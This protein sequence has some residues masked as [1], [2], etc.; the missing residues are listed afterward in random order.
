MEDIKIHKSSANNN[1]QIDPADCL[2]CL[3]KL[4]SEIKYLKCAHGFHTKC[5]N[6][7]LF[8][9]NT[10]PICRCEIYKPL[11]QYYQDYQDLLEFVESLN[12]FIDIDMVL[13]KDNIL[14][15][16]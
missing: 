14:I 15:E 6:Q 7:W 1:A 8:G 10:C 5:I 2:I 3:A 12:L 11:Y 13:P 16:D 4:S 9:H